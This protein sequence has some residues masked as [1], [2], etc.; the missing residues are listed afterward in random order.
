MAVESAVEM[1]YRRDIENS[2]HPSGR[3]TELTSTFRRQL[4]ALRA[5]EGFG[6][7][8]VIRPSETR[9]AL[10]RLLGQLPRRKA[11]QTVTPRRHAVAPL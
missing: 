5:A 9:P 10:I 11:M 8:A 2:A 7:D 6:V 1:T 4:G 3:R